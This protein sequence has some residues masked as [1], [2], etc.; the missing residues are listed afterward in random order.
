MTLS[1]PRDSSGVS[2]QDIKLIFSIGRLSL[3]K[4][5]PLQMLHI[6]VMSSHIFF[7]GIFEPSVT[8]PL[9]V[10]LSRM[11]KVPLALPLESSCLSASFRPNLPKY[12]LRENK[13]EKQ[14]GVTGLCCA[15]VM[16]EFEHL[17]FSDHYSYVL[18]VKVQAVKCVLGCL[19]HTL[20]SICVFLCVCV[21]VCALAHA[22]LHKKKGFTH[23]SA[24]ME[25]TGAT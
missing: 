14:D 3:S 18:S 5:D 10:S 8:I 12:Q 15:A 20:Q 13:T 2:R 19:R 21:Y 11:R 7:P 4:N 25:S 22:H 23:S 16:A 24:W 6:Y 9:V 17:Q 1:F